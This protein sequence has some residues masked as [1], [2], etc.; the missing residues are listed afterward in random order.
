MEVVPQAEVAPMSEV[1]QK[2]EPKDDHHKN[3][4]TFK[5]IAVAS[6]CGGAALG[7]VIL[8]S[9]YAKLDWK[10]SLKD[11]TIEVIQRKTKFQFIVEQSMP[12]VGTAFCYCIKK[13]VD[14]MCS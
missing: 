2:S 4:E 14:Y 10:A 13:L 8:I 7:G 5:A 1:V 12:Y 11:G 3:P 6:L 9:S